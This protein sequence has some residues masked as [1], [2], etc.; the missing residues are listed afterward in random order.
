ME[1]NII[2]N[3]TNLKIALYYEMKKYE[4]IENDITLLNSD[5]SCLKDI[6]NNLNATSYQDLK[7]YIFIM[8]LVLNIV[9]DEEESDLIYKKLYEIIC[10]L[11]SAKK[12]NYIEEELRLRSKFE[13]IKGI[14]NKKIVELSVL[15]SDLEKELKNDK[16]NDYKKIIRKLKHK[17][18]I[19]NQDRTLIEDFLDGKNVSDKDQILLFNQ[20]DFNNFMIKK[21]SGII[22]HSSYFDYN[23]I[24]SMLNFGFEKFEITYI[25]DK[26]VRNKVEAASNLIINT[27]EAN[28]F[29]IDEYINYLPDISNNDY[30]YEEVKGILK[31][32]LVHFQEELLEIVNMVKDKENFKEAGND[33][34]QEFKNYLYIL[35]LLTSYYYNQ[36]DI[37]NRNFDNIDE[38]DEVN[39]IFYAERNENITYLEKDLED[40]NPH[41]LEKVNRLINRLKLG[42]L[43]RDEIKFLTDCNK[44]LELRDDQIRIIFYSLGNNNYVIV[45]VLVKKKDNDLNAYNKMANRNKNIDISDEEKYQKELLKAKEVEKRYLRFIEENKRKGTSR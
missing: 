42:K 5:I 43:S 6:I 44:Q 7:D 19:T 45:G 28:I 27:I 16:R 14:I 15:K 37:Y 38:E 17:F 22:P 39:H 33:L 4:K 29:D 9:F 41:Y 30:S 35:K 24:P 18:F 8:P 36:I 11:I 32:V 2:N 13:N 34:K 26:G 10:G 1:E 23:L 21:D 20:I 3:V 25:N 12:N 31:R 40:I